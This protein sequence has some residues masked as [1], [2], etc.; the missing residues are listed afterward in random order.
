MMIDAQKGDLFDKQSA[1]KWLA[2]ARAWQEAG[3]R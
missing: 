3:G 1:P 2:L